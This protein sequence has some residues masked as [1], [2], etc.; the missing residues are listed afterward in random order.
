MIDKSVSDAIKK[1]Q[2]NKS[3]IVGKAKILEHKIRDME[4][5]NNKVKKVDSSNKKAGVM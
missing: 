5:K 3:E 2:S 4:N 1:I